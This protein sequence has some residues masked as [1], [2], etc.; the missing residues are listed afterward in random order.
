MANPMTAIACLQIQTY[1]SS[2][3]WA[4]C[5][6]RFSGSARRGLQPDDT[7]VSCFG[8]AEAP[9]PTPP[10]LLRRSVFIVVE[11]KRPQ[12][13]AK[14]TVRDIWIVNQR[15]D[16]SQQVFGFGRIHIQFSV[17]H[18]RS[19]SMVSLRCAFASVGP[20]T[21]LHDGTA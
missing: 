5:L 11:Q 21:A 4:T 14:F 3:G 8:A 15:G 12:F 13:L 9:P 7:R 20:V 16:F 19:S 2:A 6:T 10:G 18:L 17:S 1:D